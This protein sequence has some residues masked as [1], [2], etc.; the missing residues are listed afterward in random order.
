MKLNLLQRLFWCIGAQLGVLQ[1]R[2][3][4]AVTHIVMVR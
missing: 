3:I 1:H 2:Y 4:F